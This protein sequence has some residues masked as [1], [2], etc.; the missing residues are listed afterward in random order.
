MYRQYAE[1]HI[2]F[3]RESKGTTI[4]SIHRM[5]EQLD[6][7]GEVT[8]ADT[9]KGLEA[10]R[11]RGIDLEELR[12]AWHTDQWSAAASSDPASEPGPAHKPCSPEHTSKPGRGMTPGDGESPVEAEKFRALRSSVPFSSDEDQ[13]TTSSSNPDETVELSV[14]GATMMILEW[15]PQDP[16]GLAPVI[17]AVKEYQDQ[18]PIP[19]C[20]KT[21]FCPLAKGGRCRRL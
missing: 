4:P 8:V 21:P 19:Y 13:H 14:Q 17:Q 18:R 5:Q 16:K 9:A 20:S 12:E 10:L 6:K 1:Y 15:F 7:P 11:E 3:S 2:E